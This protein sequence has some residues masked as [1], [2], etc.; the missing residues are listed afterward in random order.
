MSAF[1]ND[2]A[3]LSSRAFK[4]GDSKRRGVA[5][6][7]RIDWP[8]CFGECRETIRS[9]VGACACEGRAVA[10]A[11]VHDAVTVISSGIGALRGAFELDERCGSGRIEA[12]SGSDS[13][14]QRQHVLTRPRRGLPDRCRLGRQAFSADGLP[15][16]AMR[17]SSMNLAPVHQARCPSR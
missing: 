13:N 7:F 1:Q 10:E 15:V 9:G 16:L 8:I 2:I 4:R 17:D 12:D 6:D 14:A 11:A 3:G 5:G